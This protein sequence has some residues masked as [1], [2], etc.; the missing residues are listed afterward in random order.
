MS[1][2]AFYIVKILNIKIIRLHYLIIIVFNITKRISNLNT[3]K[4]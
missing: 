2:K 1:S 4:L 3:L